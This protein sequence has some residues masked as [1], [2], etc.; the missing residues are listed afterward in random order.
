M[1]AFESQLSDK[2]I[3]DVVAFIRSIPNPPCKVTAK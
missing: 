2:E 3:W 1:V